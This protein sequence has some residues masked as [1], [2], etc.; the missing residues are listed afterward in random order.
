MMKKQITIITLLSIISCTTIFGQN[1]YDYNW[2]FG[3]AAPQQNYTANLIDFN[4]YGFDHIDS[5]ILGSGAGTGSN[6]AEISDKYGNLLF[7]SNGCRIMDSTHHIMEGGDSISYGD[8]WERFCHDEYGDGYP[9]LRNTIALPS[10]G[11]ENGYF[12]LH[13]RGEWDYNSDY[14]YM[15]ELYYSYVDMTQN[16]GKGKVIEKNRIIFSTTNLV[17][18][19]LTACKHTN[20]KDWWVIQMEKDTNIYFKVLIKEDTIEVDSQSI[21]PRFTLLSNPGQ[22]VFSPDGSKYVLYNPANECLIYDFDRETGEL[23]NLHQVE[24]QDSGAFYGVAISSNSRFLY[25]SARND[26]F[27]VDLF[28]DNYQSSLIHIAHR[29][30]FRDPYFPSTFSFS[31]LAPDCKIYIVS[32][33]TNN[34]IH[35]INKPNEKGEAC[36]FRQHSIN[37]PIRNNNFSIPNFPH[38]RTDED[39]ICDSTITWIPDEYI[40]KKINKLSVYPNPASD[41]ATISVYS[42]G[43]EQGKISIYTITGELVKTLNIDSEAT[44]SLDVRSMKPGVYAVEYDSYVNV[45]RE[46]KKLVVVK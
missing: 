40:I 24:V 32:G 27:Q 21:G 42:D 14:L 9:T 35:V 3:I 31:Q 37:L 13:K 26:L 38:F 45:G 6:N 33:T 44:K 34:H 7:Y 17:Q 20:G 1:K 29:D 2:L 16:E 19:Y 5:I 30:G 36:D 15:P 43:Y 46:V 4:R 22:A 28:A 12:L 25:L 39:Q 8:A 11:D 41:E 10:P 18:G 23:S